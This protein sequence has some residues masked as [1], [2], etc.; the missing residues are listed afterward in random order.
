MV[1]SLGEESMQSD[2]GSAASVALQLCCAPGLGLCR[3]L[4]TWG[5]QPCTAPRLGCLWVIT[6][7]IAP[8]A[9]C[10]PWL[11]LAGPPEERE[12]GI[13]SLPSPY[14]AVAAA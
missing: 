4:P 1:G 2:C 14:A 3:R 10:L 5:G 12:R 6:G 11:G 8:G 7:T 13:A 9:A